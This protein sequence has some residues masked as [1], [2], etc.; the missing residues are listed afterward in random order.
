MFN[1]KEKKIKNHINLISSSI[2][3]VLG[4]LLIIFPWFYEEQPAKLLYVL[5][6]IYG[7]NKIIE[8]IL[9]RNGT[10]HEN[11]YTAI[12]C[13][14]ASV[15]GFKFGGYTNQPMVLS[16][17]LM[18]WVGIMS[19]IKLI[20]LDYYHDREN[21]MFYVNLITFSL[22][23]LLGLLTSINLYFSETVQTLMMGFFFTVNGILSLAENGIRILVTEKG[24]K[25]KDINN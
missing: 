17:T 10:D 3:I 12:A 16:I 19:I 5:F 18:S 6:A 4:I 9:T 1:K 15:S 13:I 21:G 8:Y 24:L 23:L 14:L 20:K 2:L 7:G 22:F 11:L 25:I